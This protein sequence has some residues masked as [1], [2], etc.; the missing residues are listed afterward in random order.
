MLR[1]ILSKL[2]LET[3]GD[4]LEDILILKLVIHFLAVSPLVVECVK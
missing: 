1:H 2:L 4:K 3:L